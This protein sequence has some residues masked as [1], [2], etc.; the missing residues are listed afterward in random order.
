LRSLPAHGHGNIATMKT[1]R[2]TLL[3]APANKSVI[4]A[5]AA[6]DRA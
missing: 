1:D 2:L 5:C 4:P 3:I 6:A